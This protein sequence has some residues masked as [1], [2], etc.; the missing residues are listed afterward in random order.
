MAQISGRSDLEFK[1]EV[2]LDIYYIE[3][4]TLFL[5]LYIIFKTPFVLFNKRQAN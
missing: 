3:N 1:E 5:D 4:W 2:R